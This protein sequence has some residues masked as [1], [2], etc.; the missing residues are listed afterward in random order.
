MSGC[1][2]E[3]PLYLYLYECF[4]FFLSLF[5][6]S[7]LD[8]VYENGCMHWEWRLEGYGWGIL[9]IPWDM[10]FYCYHFLRCWESS[11]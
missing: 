9:G 10:D 7:C 11:M 8:W 1:V 3:W 6:Y 5:F 4:S 2:G